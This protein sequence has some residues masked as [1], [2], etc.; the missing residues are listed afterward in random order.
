MYS[1]LRQIDN[2]FT[3]YTAQK[4]YEYIADVKDI[5]KSDFKNAMKILSRS[6]TE[7]IVLTEI[8]DLKRILD[9]N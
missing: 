5:I 4:Y 3:R 1:L 7:D 2:R 9:V 6:A 8:Y